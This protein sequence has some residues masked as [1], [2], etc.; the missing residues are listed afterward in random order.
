[1]SSPELPCDICGELTVFEAPPC[2]DGHGGD[3]PEL[4]CTGCGAAVLVG[5]TPLAPSGVASRAEQPSRA[6]D[7]ARAEQPAPAPDPARPDGPVR[8]PHPLVAITPDGY[9]R[10][11][12]RRAEPARRRSA[13]GAGRVRDL[14]PAG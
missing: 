2:A 5:P 13:G 9:G 8:W 6:G 10:D 14:D 4:C 3:C 1:M 12:P 11:R 7:A